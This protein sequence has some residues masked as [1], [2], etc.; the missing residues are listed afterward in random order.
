LKEAGYVEGRDV[1]VEYRWAEGH[2]ERLSALAEDLLSHQVAVIVA[3]GPAA[4]SVRSILCVSR[5]LRRFSAAVSGIVYV[6][7]QIFG[8]FQ[9]IKGRPQLVAS[10]LVRAAFGSHS[11]RLAGS[12]LI[13]GLLS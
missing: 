7:H 5:M 6:A 3:N 11:V 13:P 12:V 8:S 10:S 2:Y 9:P 1:T 4:Y